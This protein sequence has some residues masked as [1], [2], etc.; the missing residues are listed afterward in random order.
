MARGRAAQPG[1][2]N[3]SANGYHYTRTED[4][5]VL[6]HHLIAAKKLGHPIDTKK[7]QVFFIDGDKTNLDPDNVGIRP[8]H[9]SSAQKRLAQLHARRQE[10]DAEIQELENLE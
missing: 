4:K 8:K 7:V 3:V 5:W 10:I 2:T 1:S 9:A 6:T